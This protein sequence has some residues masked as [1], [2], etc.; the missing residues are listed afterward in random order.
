MSDSPLDN[1]ADDVSQAIANLLASD[2]QPEAFTRQLLAINID[3]VRD[4]LLQE[5]N[6]AAKREQYDDITHRLV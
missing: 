2:L 5:W 1:T 3:N 4:I 6:D